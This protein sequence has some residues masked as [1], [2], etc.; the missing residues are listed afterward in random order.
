MKKSLLPKGSLQIYESK[1]KI[2]TT[3]QQ[4]KL[5]HLRYKVDSWQLEPSG[6][7]EKN[8]SY[9][10]FEV[11]NWEQGNKKMGIECKHRAHFYGQYVLL[12]NCS[13][14]LYHLIIWLQ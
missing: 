14:A 7:I 10:E 3:S 12:S 13:W 2:L 9:W 6:E 5:L 8:S 4:T 11:N 1:K